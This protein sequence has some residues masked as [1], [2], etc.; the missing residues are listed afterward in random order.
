M[1]ARPDCILAPPLLLHLRSDCGRQRSSDRLGSFRLRRLVTGGLLL[2]ELL[3]FRIGDV[4]ELLHPSPG[5]LLRDEHAIVLVDEDSNRVVEL[6][7]EATR[8][9]DVTQ[10]GAIAIIGL[11]EAKTVVHYPDVAVAVQRD[12]LGALE[13]SDGIAVF[14]ELADEVAVGVKNFDSPV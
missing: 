7:Q 8:P 11:H 4:A 10:Q 9:A 6:S 14:S 1:A 2:L 12:P 13:A 5:T 3:G